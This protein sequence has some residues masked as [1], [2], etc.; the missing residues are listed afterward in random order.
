MDRVRIILLILA[1]TWILAACGAQPQ[2]ID[3]SSGFPEASAE[4]ILSPSKPESEVAGESGDE[5]ENPEQYGNDLLEEAYGSENGG[6][7]PERPANSGSLKYGSGR[8]ADELKR[9]KSAAGSSNV[10]QS[11][12]TGS[13]G[14]V[15]ARFLEA[16]RLMDSV[17]LAETTGEDVDYYELD[18]EPETML[19]VE[20]MSR[21]Q[22][23][24][25]GETASG[26]TAQV[27]VSI[28]MVSPS[29]MMDEVWDRLAVMVASGEWDT[30]DAMSYLMAVLTERIR[31]PNAPT[32]TTETILEVTKD[33]QGR[34][35][36]DM[37]ST[38][39]EEF[40]MDILGDWADIFEEIWYYLY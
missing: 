24:V 6:S 26:D 30:E 32:F 20:L 4:E 38:A 13:P 16:F 1:M 39:N 35:I 14:G 28:T 2:G 3:E 7:P 23:S 5:L 40:F 18:D 33:Q 12:G 15:A 19:A 17:G 27:R 8:K 29:A 11:Y 31:D 36:I 37:E 9:G 22:Y 10:R 34:W 25:L 21:M